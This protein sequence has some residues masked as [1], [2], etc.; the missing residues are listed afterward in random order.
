MLL[1]KTAQPKFSVNSI[2]TRLVIYRRGQ[3][4]CPNDVEINIALRRL[5]ILYVLS[6]HAPSN[7]TVIP[8]Y[9]LCLQ[10]HDSLERG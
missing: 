8:N 5:S 2:K 1:L 10:A 3:Y 7:L 4:L 6:V 9:Q